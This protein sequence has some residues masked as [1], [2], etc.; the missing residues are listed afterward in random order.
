M[1]SLSPVLTDVIVRDFLEN[2]IVNL[3][4]Q[5]NLCF[6]GTRNFIIVF[7]KSLRS[8]LEVN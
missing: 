1:I 5:E 7:L 2:S 6:C 3:P 4:Y 8:G